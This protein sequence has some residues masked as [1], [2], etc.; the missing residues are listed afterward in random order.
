MKAMKRIPRSKRHSRIDAIH[1]ETLVMAAKN[2]VS[3]ILGE[4]G[5]ILHL[6]KGE[7]Y[8]LNE[9]GTVI[10]ELLQKPISAAQIAGEVTRKFEVSTKQSLADVLLF[11]NRMREANL[12]EVREQVSKP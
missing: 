7:Y 4:E 5:V 10:W 3:S 8:G 11:L 9:V 1:D 6:G 12:I 2:Q